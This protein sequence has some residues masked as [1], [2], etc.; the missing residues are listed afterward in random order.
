[1]CACVHMHAQAVNEYRGG[2]MLTEV[3]VE[4]NLC[5]EIVDRR[6]K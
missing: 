4:Q 2:E 3:V 5:T 6:R 1:M